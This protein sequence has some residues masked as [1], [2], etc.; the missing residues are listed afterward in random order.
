[1]PNH[2]QV[3][4]RAMI[5]IGS[6]LLKVQNTGP[7]RIPAFTNMLCTGPVGLAR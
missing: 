1:M 3:L 7:S 2:F 6:H 4:I 5:G